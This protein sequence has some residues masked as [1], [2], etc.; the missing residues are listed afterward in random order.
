MDGR[1]TAAELRH[2]AEK[3]WVLRE[4]VFSAAQCAA[5][6]EATDA[7][8][9]HARQQAD[10]EKLLG[11][12]AG[13]DESDGAHF[14]RLVVKGAVDTVAGAPTAQ[15]ADVFAQWARHPKILPALEQLL[16]CAPQFT[17]SMILVTP[18]HPRREEPAMRAVLRENDEMVWHR[19]IRP[20]WGVRQAAQPGH[21]TTS[22]LHTCT[23]LSDVSTAD[24]G[25]T[26]VLS[27]SHRMD[28]ES[29]NGEPPPPA[30]ELGRG[31]RVANQVPDWQAALAQREQACGPEGSVM[32]FSEA[33]IHAGLAVLSE[34]TRY[35]MFVDCTP[36]AIATT[37]VA[38][39]QRV[40]YR[41]RCVEEA[42][43]VSGLAAEF[44]NPLVQ[45]P[46]A[47]AAAALLTTGA[48]ANDHHPGDGSGG[49]PKL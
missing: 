16:G 18:P 9:R 5:L 6:R 24:D 1:L 10:P 22:W 20:K 47:A 13:A 3:G 21:V 32:H 33:L 43:D 40:G 11:V 23:F 19:G 14:G 7:E 2:F 31:G 49:K 35:A 17:G 34:R 30:S 39:D 4:G 15:R 44:D 45:M 27:G 26:L 29:L 28:V 46:P 48:D 38:T 42:W 41:P 8:L 12:V 25:G 36:S 37:D